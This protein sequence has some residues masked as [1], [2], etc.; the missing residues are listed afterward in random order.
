MI[1]WLI[2]LEGAVCGGRVAVVQGAPVPG[3]GHLPLRVAV[4]PLPAAFREVEELML[5]RGIVV[6]YETVRRWC[7]RSRAEQAARDTASGLLLG[8]RSTDCRQLVRPYGACARS[9]PRRCRPPRPRD[10]H[11]RGRECCSTRRSRRDLRSWSGSFAPGA[12]AGLG[13]ADSLGV[14][15][16]VAP[17]AGASFVADSLGVGAGVALA[18]G[19][20]FLASSAAKVPAITLWPAALG[21]GSCF[22]HAQV[23]WQTLATFAG[24]SPVPGTF[25]WVVKSFEAKAPATSATLK[26]AESTPGRARVARRRAGGRPLAVCCPPA[27]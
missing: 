21:W 19:A 27:P 24:T 8:V 17:A 5:E 6:S 7:A 9:R 10:R 26:P 22:V 18:A 1:F 16:G 23:S 11:P 25:T 14:G 4:P 15:A 3:R 13:V 20:S 12:L 2:V